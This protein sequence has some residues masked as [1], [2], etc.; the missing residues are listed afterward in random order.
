MPYILDLIKKEDN[1]RGEKFWDARKN[2][3]LLRCPYCPK[4]FIANEKHKN[5]KPKKTYDFLKHKEYCYMNNRLNIH[6][7]DFDRHL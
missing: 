3:L 2:R 6:I 1:L 4:C 5:G 7:S